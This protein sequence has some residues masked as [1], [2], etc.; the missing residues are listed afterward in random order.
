MSTSDTGV[1][2]DV[3]PPTTPPETPRDSTKASPR[4]LFV[5]LVG[6]VVVAYLL[7]LGSQALSIYNDDIPK[8][9]QAVVATIG[10]ILGA[11]GLF[12]FLNMA[13]EGLPRKLSLGV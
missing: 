5:G 12:Y 11:A 4:K 3:A 13:V 6:L 9:A 7:V 10:G 2:G 8:I 1:A